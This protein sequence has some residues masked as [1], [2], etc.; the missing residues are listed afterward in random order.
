[1]P[2]DESRQY[3]QMY[4]LHSFFQIGITFFGVAESQY[5]FGCRDVK[6]YVSTGVLVQRKILNHTL[7]QQRRITNL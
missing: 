1:M 5:E 2:L 6:F 3:L 4:L 7:N